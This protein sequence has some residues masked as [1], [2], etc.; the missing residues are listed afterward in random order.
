M[1][2]STSWEAAFAFKLPFNGQLLCAR[3]YAK[4]LTHVT[5]L[6]SATPSLL[7]LSEFLV[8]ILLSHPTS[9]KLSSVLLPGFPFSPY[10]IF[11]TISLTSDT[12]PLRKPLLNSSRIKSSKLS[13]M[14]QANRIIASSVSLLCHV[15]TCLMDV[16]YLNYMKMLI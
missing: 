16:N 5:S 2:T 11:T 3:H 8:L 9:S 14:Y 4:Y 10:S 15:Q 1:F 7:T 12:A 6:C 13:T